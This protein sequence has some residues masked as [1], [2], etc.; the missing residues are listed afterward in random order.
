MIFLQILR[1]IRALSYRNQDMNDHENSPT[2]PGE[3]LDQ[4]TQRLAQLEQDLQEVRSMLGYYPPQEPS[5]PRYD[6][7]LSS[8]LAME[9][10]QPGHEQERYEYRTPPTEPGDE[11]DSSDSGPAT[12]PE[13]SPISPAGATLPQESLESNTLNIDVLEQR[14]ELVVVADLPGTG[15]DEIDVQFTTDGLQIEGTPDTDENGGEDEEEELSKTYIVRERPQSWTRT[16][17][18]PDTVERDE[19]FVE[20]VE[21]KNGRLT[22]TLQKSVVGQQISV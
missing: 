14:D 10:P 16:V 12:I 2:G 17:Y 18:L 6:S 15:E 4:V 5:E 3:S 8:P 13:E 11:I 21:F 22:I 7:S 19:A 20:S 1:Q 9:S